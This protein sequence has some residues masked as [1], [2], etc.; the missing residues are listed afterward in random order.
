LTDEG[1]PTLLVC[2]DGSEH[3]DHAIKVAARLFPGANAKVLHIWEPVENLVA[4]YAVLSPYL[5]EDVSATDDSI[6]RQSLELAERGAKLAKGGGLAAS[7]HSANA[8]STVWEAVIGAANELH[9]DVIITGTRSL[10]GVREVVASALSHALLQR[11]EIPVLAIPS[12]A[13][14]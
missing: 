13:E 11:S 12:P 1:K 4:R 10:R 14:A 8:P 6:G 9:A 2:Y 5:G 3:A 7:A